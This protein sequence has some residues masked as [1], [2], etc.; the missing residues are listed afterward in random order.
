M[1]NLSRLIAALSALASDAAVRPLPPRNL[2]EAAVRGDLGSVRAFLDGGAA[3][4]ERTIGFA[5]PLAAAAGRGHL[6]VVDLLLARGANPDPQGVGLP[7]LS[8]AIANRRVEVVERL[9]EAGAPIGK[10]RSN[11]RLAVKSQHWDMVDALLR[12]GAD[13]A[14]MSDGERTQLETFAAH[15][16]PRSPEYRQRFREEQARQAEQGL[17][18]RG[19]RLLEEAERARHE[20]EAIAEIERDPSLVHAKT[21]GATP[22]LTLAVGCGAGE[23]V[24]VMLSKGASPNSA[25][26]AETALARAAARSDAALVQ[27][28]LGAGADP[29]ASGPGSPHPL[30]AA[31][32]AGS[33]AC[34][35]LLLAHGSRPRARDLRLAIE[36]AA[37]PGALTMVR[38]LES[39]KTPAA[40]AKAAAVPPSHEPEPV[41]EGA[42]MTPAAE[43]VADLRS[44]EGLVFAATGS[45]D[46]LTQME[47]QM[48]VEVRGG[49]FKPSVTKKTQILVAGAKASSKLEKARAEGVRILTEPQ[50]R[51]LCRNLTITDEMKRRYL[52]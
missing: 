4:E 52:G 45:F 44:I 27:V 47:I 16:Q 40:R 25:G 5:S 34:V 20:A 41:D 50:F 7:L 18:A 39:L 1:G 13:P 9:L 35:D 3:I 51:A 37:G 14:W 33:L 2:T 6:E 11:F 43:E 17:G 10:Y 32:R 15:Q 36:Q 31:A 42:E 30:L 28:L 38:R 49:I 21:D 46:T 19:G 29:N 26:P 22:V 12:R 48:S 23:L 24:R 8:F